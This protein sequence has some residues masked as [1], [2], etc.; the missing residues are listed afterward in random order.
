[1]ELE[2]TD[3]RILDLLQKDGRMSWSALAAEL[4]LSPPAAADRV[5][6]LEERGVVK[7]YAAIVNPPAVGAALLAFV[8]VTLD[9]PANRAG[10]LKKIL[11]LDEVQEAHHIAGDF[12]YLL[13]VRTRDTAHLEEFLSNVL[14]ELPG[15]ARTRTT[16]ALGTAKETSRIRT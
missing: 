7:G 2:K 6:R 9:R 4:D 15:V 5:R 11:K 10:F 8:A 14:K 13:K 16:I 3:L 1:M 12:D